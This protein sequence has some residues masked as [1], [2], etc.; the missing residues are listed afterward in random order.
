MKSDL[1]ANLDSLMTYPEFPSN[2]NP[3][4][5]ELALEDRSALRR[6][7]GLSTELADISEVEYRQLRLER[8]VLVGVWTEGSAAEAEA[9][10]AELAALAETAGSEVLEGV[11]QRRD[12]PDAS[13]Y[14]GSGKA[15]ELREIVLATGA[16]TV[17]CDGELSP[18][19]LTALERIVKV[20]VIDRTALI[21]DIFAQHATSREGKAQVSLAQMEYMLPRLRG[22]GESMSR[23]AGGRAGGAG[24]GV[25]TR[26]PGETKIETDRRRIRERMSKLRREIKDMKKIRDTQRSG[27]RRNEVPSV[28]IVGYT[29]AGKSSLLN[30]LTGAGVLVENALFATLEP[31]TRRGEFE[32][33]RPFVLTDT[34]GFV[35]HLPTQLVEAF[36]STLEEVVDADLLVHV[37]DGSDANPLAQIRAVR[38]VINE[39]V[40]EQDAKPA[41]ELLVV[42]KIDA[43]DGVSLAHL[44]GAL[45]DAVFVSARTGEGLDRLSA[46]MSELVESTDTT[47]DVTIPYDRGDLVARVHSEGR[48]D[49]TEHTTD[50]TRIKAR[51]PV[52]L[53]AGLADFATF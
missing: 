15:A 6:V 49:A 3:S 47:V 24:G 27:R 34:V 28:A 18:A 38:E 14:I 52:A 53:A 31:T 21:L 7:A 30:A 42:N 46:R 39:V 33:G 32:D 10:L 40:A 44:R 22:W 4:A 48:I 23:Q 43:A 19:Q 5:G 25:G 1:R 8:V 16:D 51:V 26:G 29:N 2:D 13:T 9:S 45:P 17:I 41:P 36:R 12:K 37:V 50:G 35:R 11:V 20:K